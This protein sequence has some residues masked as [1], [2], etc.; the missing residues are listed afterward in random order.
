MKRVQF[1]GP[2][3]RCVGGVTVILPVPVRGEPRMMERGCC[4]YGKE[5]LEMKPGATGIVFHYD[6]Q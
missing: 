5:A 6:G 1:L 4:G 2:S 3:C